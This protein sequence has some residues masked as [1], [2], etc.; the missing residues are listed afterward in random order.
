MVVKRDIEQIEEPWNV[1]AKI[2]IFHSPSE[3]MLEHAK[4]A[5][6]YVSKVY[7]LGRAMAKAKATG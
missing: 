7:I 3:L 5:P 2:G 6:R 1:E 4:K